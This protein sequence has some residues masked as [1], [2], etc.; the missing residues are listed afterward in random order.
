MTTIY[1]D[2]TCTQ[3]EFAELV[4]VT[5]PSVSR[6]LAEGALPPD[7]TAGE[8][9]LAYCYRLRE[10]AAGRYSGGGDLDLAQ[11]RA[12][13]A[14]AQREGIELKNAV[15]RRE[16]APVELLAQTLATAS[17][18]VAERFDM[19]P[20]A[21]RKTCPDLPEAARDTVL[22][23]LA[24]ARNEWVRQTVALVAAGLD[25]P[26]PDEDDDQAGAVADAEA[27]PK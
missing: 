17:T 13:L 22:A 2:Q 14:R 12:A 26:M 11:E 21:L 3:A 19:L 5:Q 4:G 1:L 20:A 15:L 27:V 23:V 24:Q 7:G 18:A 8:W 9:L 6:W 10:Q 16:F 25:V